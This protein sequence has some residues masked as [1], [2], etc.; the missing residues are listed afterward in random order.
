MRKCLLT[1]CIWIGL[2]TGC[3]PI[4]QQTIDSGEV[5]TSFPDIIE[6]HNLNKQSR[7]EMWLYS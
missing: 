1:L 2:L 4:H 6:P 5:M 7:A 3:N